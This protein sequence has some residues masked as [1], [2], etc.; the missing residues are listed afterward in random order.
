MKKNFKMKIFIVLSAMFAGPSHIHAQT[1]I[2]FI[3]TNYEY[4]P[5]VGLT[6]SKGEVGFSQQNSTTIPKPGFPGTIKIKLDG[7]EIGQVNLSLT[8]PG[9]FTASESLGA[10]TDLGSPVSLRYNK[11]APYSFD[12]IIH[13]VKVN[14]EE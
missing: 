4:F 9:I 14:M 12:G 13:S 5:S 1:A 6:Q 10:G 11:K 8:V 3:Y 2:D 7:K